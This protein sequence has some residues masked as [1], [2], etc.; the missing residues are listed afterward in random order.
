MLVTV[1]MM[2]GA[3]GSRVVLQGK[4]RKIEKI[5][6]C[7]C[8][9]WK[10]IQEWVVEESDT[11]LI[12]KA[13]SARFSHYDEHYLVEVVSREGER[14]VVVRRS[15]IYSARRSI[16]EVHAVFDVKFTTKIKE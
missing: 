8:G 2:L 15:D 11:V 1:V 13:G 7:Y 16:L 10:K 3:E 12:R 9:A 5:T 4:K 14:R 6:Y